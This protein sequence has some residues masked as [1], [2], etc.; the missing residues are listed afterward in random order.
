[1]W[2]LGFKLL[3]ICSVTWYDLAHLSGAHFLSQERLCSLP[4]YLFPASITGEAEISQVPNRIWHGS[5]RIAGTNSFYMLRN[6]GR[7]PLRAGLPSSYVP[8]EL[9]SWLHY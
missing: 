7:P 8:S 1:M 5:H 2:I 3:L 4:L 6:M 9:S